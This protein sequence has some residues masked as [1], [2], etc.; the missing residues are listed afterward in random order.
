M[1]EIKGRGQDITIEL[2]HFS[3]E[4]DQY[5][6]KVGEK[7][8]LMSSRLLIVNIYCHT[9]AMILSCH[10]KYLCLWHTIL[11]VSKYSNK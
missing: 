3:N 7:C 8:M 1:K 10:F 2:I 6:D 11:F 5:T 4:M 9:P